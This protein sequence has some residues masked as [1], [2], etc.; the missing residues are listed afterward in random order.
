M[1]VSMRVRGKFITNHGG[2]TARTWLRVARRQE[3]D[4]SQL[5][6]SYMQCLCKCEVW[7]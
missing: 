4:R 1:L 5:S 3:Q 6:R 7:R 2:K